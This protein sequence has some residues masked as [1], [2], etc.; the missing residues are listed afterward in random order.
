MNK[1]IARVSVLGV[2][3]VS[4]CILTA[5]GGGSSKSGSENNAGQSST[6]SA[7]TRS[8]SSSSGLSSSVSSSSLATSTI[9]ANFVGV[10]DASTDEGSDGFDQFFIAIDASGKISTYDFAG[11]TFDDWGNCYWIEKDA[12]LI[13]P[14]GGSIY[15]STVTLSGSEGEFEDLEI[16]VS[17]GVMTTKFQDVD[18]SDDDGNT[19]EMISETMAKSTRSLESFTPKCT[20]NFNLARSL[21][22]AKQAKSLNL[23]P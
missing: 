7:S 6:S 8:S 3:L 15:R 23:R 16:T 1:I 19:T 13:T 14:L 9:P 17:G 2:A 21:I 12:F 18:D 11:D 5:C 22:P 20:D 10:W 4:S